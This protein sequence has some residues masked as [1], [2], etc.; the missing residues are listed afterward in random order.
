MALRARCSIGEGFADDPPR[1]R[2]QT[3]IGDRVQ[4]MVQLRIEIFEVVEGAAEKANQSRIAGVQ[5]AHRIYAEFGAK[6]RQRRTAR[7]LTQQELAA[8]IKLDASK[9]LAVGSV[10]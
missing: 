4:P 10:F 1:G 2:V 5:A 9:N 7:R 8:L 3:R 6:V